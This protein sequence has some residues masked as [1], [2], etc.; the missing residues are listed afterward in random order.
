MAS[1]LGPAQSSRQRSQISPSLHQRA[2]RSPTTAPASP[3]D[4]LS[5]RSGSTSP[6]DFLFKRQP[7]L[8]RSTSTKFNTTRESSTGPESPRTF[9]LLRRRR[10]RS[11]ST[12][13][14]VCDADPNLSSRPLN[15]EVRKPSPRRQEDEGLTRLFRSKDD[16]EIVKSKGQP[17]VH[18]RPIPFEVK[19]E[20]DS[21]FGHTKGQKR[22]LALRI[23][24]DDGH[25]WYD[26][27]EQEE[28]AHLLS[29]APNTPILASRRSSALQSGGLTPVDAY[30]HGQKHFNSTL[31]LVLPKSP[32][33]QDVAS[34]HYMPMSDCY[35]ENALDISEPSARRRKRSKSVLLRGNVVTDQQPLQGELESED[36]V[37]RSRAFPESDR[38]DIIMPT[39]LP[40]KRHQASS[41][42]LDE[43]FATADKDTRP[44]EQTSPNS[45]LE[46]RGKKRPVNLQL[47][48]RDLEEVKVASP[49]RRTRP[50]SMVTPLSATMK[51]LEDPFDDENSGSSRP[52]NASFDITSISPRSGRTGPSGAD[53]SVYLSHTPGPNLSTIEHPVP[54]VKNTKA[55][56]IL[57]MHP[58]N[59]NLLVPG[60]LPTG[61]HVYD[62]LDIPCR[63]IHLSS[64]DEDGDTCKEKKS[65][66]S[67]VK[68]WLR[69]KT[70]S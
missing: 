21:F 29:S 9:D 6:I 37:D 19:A 55:A 12:S 52:R 70:S 22:E 1:V 47:H 46:T 41:A 16:T 67:G 26:R 17:A 65:L 45:R 5:S 25:L 38:S 14:C 68:K 56:S 61:L 44:D 18:F 2:T 60:G 7:S 20:F 31:Q 24:G 4:P 32:H 59:E 28:F 36:V 50:R 51:S 42:L 58:G 35:A 62:G 66:S 23:K 57:G 3:F 69:S 27:I 13:S 43:A 54:S 11:K 63:S 15:L 48:F 30:S 53:V 34:F 33:C 49:L 64:D 39:F 8:R 40:L 10:S